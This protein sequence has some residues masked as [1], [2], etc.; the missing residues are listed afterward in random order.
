MRRRR[1]SWS[2]VVGPGATTGEDIMVIKPLVYWEVNNSLEQ[3]NSA[4]VQTASGARSVSRRST[5]CTA[6]SARRR[7]WMR[8]IRPSCRPYPSDCR[9]FRG[10]CP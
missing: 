9:W 8:P 4:M 6:R 7:W 10:W 1:L 2:T 3:M 5:G